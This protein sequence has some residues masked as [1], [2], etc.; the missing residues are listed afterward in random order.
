MAN[1]DRLVL[2]TYNG[3]QN[4]MVQGK[5]YENFAVNCLKPFFTHKIDCSLDII[6]KFNNDV[7]DTLGSKKTIKRKRN[8]QPLETSGC[9]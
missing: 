2:H 1:N 5:N 7:K 4:V 8:Q 9:T 6:T 3:T